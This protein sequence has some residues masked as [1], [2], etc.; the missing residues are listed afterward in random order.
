MAGNVSGTLISGGEQRVSAVVVLVKT[1]PLR[2]GFRLFSMAEMSPGLTLAEV[3]RTFPAVVSAVDTTIE[4]GL[5]TVLNGGNV[6]GTHISGGEQNI[7][8]GGSAVDTT[9]EEG[10]QTVLNG[11]NVSGTHISGGEQNISSGGSAVDTTIEVGLQT[12]FDG[13]SVNGTMIHGGEQHISSG[14]ER[15]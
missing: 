15:D 14:E 11:G 7:S 6:S 13:G 4:E 1:P 2:R 9:I 3:S 12:V 5:Q 8:S 10:L